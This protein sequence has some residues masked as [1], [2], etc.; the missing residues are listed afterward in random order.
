MKTLFI[1]GIKSGKSA[2]AEEYTLSF[3][4]KKPL[5]LATNE[6]YDEEMNMKIKE[7]KERRQELF[8]TLEEPLKIVQTVQ[9]SQNSTVLVETLS[10]WLNNMLYHKHSKSEILKELQKLL[11]S[12]KNIIFV[13]DDVSCSVISSSKE[14]RRFVEL[15]GLIAQRVAEVC[16]SV[17]HITAGLKVKIK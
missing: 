15:N 17:Y 13:M 5:Y 7:H 6:L 11:C 4:A 12:S 3:N 9:N 16:E 1:G 14:T 8:E 2:L 10:M